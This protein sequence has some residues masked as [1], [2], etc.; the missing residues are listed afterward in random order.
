MAN[1]YLKYCES[2]VLGRS[3]YRK[4]FKF[5]FVLFFRRM[6]DIL[7]VLFCFRF[8]C[9]MNKFIA[10]PM[11]HEK[12]ISCGISSPISIQL[13]FPLNFI[14]SKP[15]HVVKF[16]FNEYC[17]PLL[18]NIIPYNVPRKKEGSFALAIQIKVFHN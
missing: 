13:V 11:F 9:Q 10:L 5:F 12:M 17:L 15:G 8:S 2:W 7:K 1:K 16:S 18:V 14:M 3:L 6:L 4:I